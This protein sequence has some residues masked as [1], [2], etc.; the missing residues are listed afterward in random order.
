MGIVDNAVKD[1]VGEG[2][3]AEHDITPQYWN[4]CQL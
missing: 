4:D 1:G 3:I 2:G